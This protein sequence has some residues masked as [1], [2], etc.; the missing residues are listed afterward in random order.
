MGRRKSDVS[1]VKPGLPV[2]YRLRFAMAVGALLKNF[3]LR[4]SW[5]ECY[6]SAADIDQSPHGKVLMNRFSATPEYRRLFVVKSMSL[7][8]FCLTALVIGVFVPR[9]ASAGLIMRIDTDSKTFF[10][11]G[12]DTGTADY[13]QL[14]RFT[15]GTYS[16]QFIHYFSTTVP[17]FGTVTE[18]AANLFA[19]GATIPMY[20]HMYMISNFGLNYV[21]MD[22]SSSSGDITTLTGNGPSA[23]L[24]YAG[25]PASDI[26]LF[27]SLIGDTLVR[28]IGTGY[29]P[30]S[31]QAVPEPSTWV[32]LAGGLACAGWR[33]C[34][35]R[36]RA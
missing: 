34:R 18:S 25:L 13:S 19:E 23:S 11:D 14:D 6:P 29:S 32:L 16:L 36:K 22:L 33:A 30:I 27:E 1:L 12:S 9:L 3:S 5:H 28:S 24:S 26:P 21:F 2:G 8:F 35:C 15:P 4:S 10:I 31:V 7:R 17:Q 20:G